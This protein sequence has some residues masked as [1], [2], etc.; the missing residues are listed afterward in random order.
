MSL[1]QIPNI[2]KIVALI[3]NKAHVLYLYNTVTSERS[4]FAIVFKI[5]LQSKSRQIKRHIQ[6]NKR[7]F[8]K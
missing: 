6:P 1:S 4:I 2:V 7:K 3:N 5:Q 8:L